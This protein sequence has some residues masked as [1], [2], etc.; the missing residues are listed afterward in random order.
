[1]CGKF[2]CWLQWIFSF[3]LFSY[4]LKVCCCK[5]VEYLTGFRL[6]IAQNCDADDCNFNYSRKHRVFTV[7]QREE[8][9]ESFINILRKGWR[10]I[11]EK[12]WKYF[13]F[14]DFRFLSLNCC[15]LTH[16]IDWNQHNYRHTPAYI[17]MNC[18]H[19]NQKISLCSS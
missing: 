15:I 8:L 19:L 14:S 9:L 16:C 2:E 5:F 7:C 17:A 4:I 1:M 10:R 18:L 6:H 12:N 3:I 13:L 11:F